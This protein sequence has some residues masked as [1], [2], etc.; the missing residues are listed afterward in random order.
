MPTELIQETSPTVYRKDYQ[1]Y[2]FTLDAVALDFQLD[3]SRS[4]V[5]STLKFTAKND[6]PADLVLNAEDISLDAIYLNGQPMAQDAYELSEQALVIAQLSGSFELRISTTLDPA[7]NSLFMGLYKSGSGFFTQCEAEGFRRITYFPDRPDV[8]SVYT[9]TLSGDKQKYPYLLSNGNLVSSTDLP[10]GRHQAVWHDPFHKPSYL[11]ALVAGDFDVREK[12]VQTH[13][14]RDVLLQVYSDKGSRDKTEW[15]LSSLERSLVWDEKRFGLELDL[16]RFMIV[17]V[18]DFNMG[19]MENKG[20]NIFNSGYVLADP[21]TATDANFSAVEAVIGHE[22]FHNWTGN[23]VTC[24]DWFQLSLKEG[25]T[26]F[27]DQEFTADMM[28]AGLDE[29]AA[30]SAR[31]VKRIDDV[32]ILRAGQFPEDAGPMAHPIRPDSYESIGNFYTATV[33]EK[34]AEVIR[35][36][37]TLLGA[38]G[39]RDGMDEYFRRHDGQA[40]TCDDFVNAMEYVYAKSHPQRDLSIFRRWYSQAGTPRVRVQMSHDKQQQTVTLTLTQHTPL[41]GVEK[42]RKDFNKKPFHIPFAIGLLSA[43]GQALALRET[44]DTSKSNGACDTG[45]HTRLLELTEQSQSWTF[46]DIAERPVPSLLRDFSAPVTVQYEWTDQELAVLAKADPNPFARWEA[47]QALATREIIGLASK[48]QQGL[49][50]A[51][52]ETFV[53][54]WKNNLQDAGLDAGY[55]ARLL[56]LPS[57]K[58]LAEQMDPIEPVWLAKARQAARENLGKVAAAQWSATLQGNDTPGPYSPDPISAGRRSLKNLALTFLMAA[59]DEAACQQALVQYQAAQNMTDCMGALGAIVNYHHGD[60]RQEAIVD[61]YE[62]W[63]HNPLVIDKWFALQATAADTRTE[64][65]R[66]LMAHPAFSLRNPN[67]ARSL[68]FQFCMNNAEGFHSEDGSGYALWTE[69]VLALD[70]INPEVASR[71][72]R[73]M[74]NWAR[75]TPAL[76]SQMKSSLEQVR[77]HR[78]L[79]SNVS[80]IVSKALNI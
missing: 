71:L 74:D 6:G 72:A 77:D 73:V 28:A 47:G 4:V 1:P 76:R 65:I 37:H 46:T 17:A 31:A 62:K 40:V 67:R 50:A 14:G 53:Q 29:Q 52:S 56:A 11:F 43:D 57:E 23:R 54:V 19:A 58:F 3:E 35:M 60:K 61:F 32:S 15:A 42:I 18:R 12:T 36:Q 55:R 10:D 16:D 33:Y 49:Q 45:D 75:Y 5:T 39:F 44:G 26:V 69:A 66:G 41:V 25:L 34:G 9:V 48:L 38:A 78:D 64:T 22:Y 7:A 27:R 59:G 13:N 80:E 51:L 2:P 68:I 63:Q 70:G 20:L 24:R 21:D 30:A 79:S 8:M